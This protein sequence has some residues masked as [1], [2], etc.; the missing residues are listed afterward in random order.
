[1]KRIVRRGATVG[2]AAVAE[3]QGSHPPSTWPVRREPAREP[4]HGEAYSVDTVLFGDVRGLVIDARSEMVYAALRYAAHVP[5]MAWMK[6][7]QHA[8]TRVPTAVVLYRELMDRN[9]KLHETRMRHGHAPAAEADARGAVREFA[10]LVGDLPAD[11]PPVDGAQDALHTLVKARGM[12]A[13]VVSLLPDAASRAT[14][15]RTNSM[16]RPALGLDAFQTTVTG[17]NVVAFPDAAT[18]PRPWLFLELMRRLGVVC[19]W[20]SVAIVSTPAAARAAAL[21]G[22]WPVGVL[23]SASLPLG[24]TSEQEWR[25]VLFVRQDKRRRALSDAFVT[26]GAVAVINHMGDVQGALTWIDDMTSQGTRPGGA[27]FALLP[28]GASPHAEWRSFAY[29]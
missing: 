23:D 16:L 1:M 12:R 21:A 6:S 29:P 18:F 17:I 26:A 4:D 10:Q 7:H 5:D 3:F 9:S 24:V 25:T 13:G 11:L 22:A 19:P 20:H 14:V 8:L 15:A 27:P 28:A 2:R